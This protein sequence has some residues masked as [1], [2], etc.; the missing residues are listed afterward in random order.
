MR[1]VAQTEKYG[2]SLINGGHLFSGKL[3]KD[4]ADPPLVDG[5][6]MVN[7]GVGFLGEATGS[8]QQRGIEQTFAG[9][10]GDGYDTDQRKALV[11]NDVGR[12][13]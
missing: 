13:Y 3:A 1:A 11:V 2:Q 7:Q 5:S 6:Q 8:R 9:S 12:D 4:A 10:S